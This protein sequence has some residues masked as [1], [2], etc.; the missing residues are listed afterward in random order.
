M[1]TLVLTYYDNP[2]ML[3]KQ[4]EYWRKY[5]EN[6]N[7]QI[8]IIDD[9]SPNNP[10]EKVLTKGLFLGNIDVSLY[11]IKED[12]FQNTVG[13]RN[14]GFTQAPEGWVF[15]LDMDHIV[16][17]ESMENLLQQLDGLCPSCYYVPDRRVMLR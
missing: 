17:S 6:N 2:L 1:I 3:R 14:L 5:P 4:L 7:V 13:A 12:I 9:G 15:N 11:R 10:A 16:P 8:V